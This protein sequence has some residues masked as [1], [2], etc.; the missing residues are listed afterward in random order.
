MKRH[1]RWLLLAT[2]IGSILATG[3]GAQ[4]AGVP[5]GD[6]AEP[7]PSSDVAPLPTN[8]VRGPED[9][10]TR[11][12]PPMA[13]PVDPATFRLGPGDMLR[14]QTWGRLSLSSVFQVDPEGYLFVPGSG[15]IRVQGRTLADLRTEILKRLQSRYRGVSLDLRLS[16]PR[17]FVVYLTGQVKSPGPMVAG[18]S[19]RAGDVIG[20][21]L[22]LENASR[23]QIRVAHVD[24]SQDIADL[25]LFLLTGRQDFN[26]LLRDGDVINVPV[27]TD[28]VWAQGAVGRPGRFE[29]GPTDSLLTLLLLA[30]DP[31]AAAAAD[32]ALLVRWKDAFTP[33]SLWVRL[34]EVYARQ[35]NP[36][37][38]EG[39]RFYV[40]FIPQY[41][42]QHEAFILGELARPGVYPI[43]EGRHRLTDLVTA[44][45]GFLSTADL[46]AIRVHRRNPAAGEKDPEL[47]RLLRLSRDQLTATEYVKL[48]TKLA[49]LRE[50]YRVDWARLTEN[51]DH[52][53]LLL[54]DA[55]IVRVERLVSSV[56]VDG[57]V[58]RPGILSFRP[59]FDVHDYIRQ[60][61]GFT[62]R[63][64]Q[65]RIRVTRAVTGQTLPAKN[66][67]ALDPGDFV[68]VPD[69]PDK[70]FWDYSRETLT[71]LAQ[72]ATVIIAIRSVRN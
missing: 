70:S 48:T 32:G 7:L 39:D 29:L 59:G 2:G 60:A 63:A 43:T 27:A 45:G 23:R 52:L 8:V 38:R 68:W 40:Y 16:R 5:G 4:S 56:R 47:E 50:D 69:R 66:V 1:V 62:D 14:L 65:G 67:K 64:W 11:G 19:T 71:G 24:G 28:F 15:S 33:E 6:L 42:Q 21:G 25:D 57:E 10:A 44:A 61:G 34:D 41:H 12:G 37:L 22:L 36:A 53:D 35:T 51:R 17:Q 13:G 20:P 72:V 30:G 26:P 46:S 58:R 9:G 31:A 55:D 54:R 3:V 49:S 18:G